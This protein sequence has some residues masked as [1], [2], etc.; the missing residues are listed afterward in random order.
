MAQQHIASS[1]ARLLYEF[2]AT[3][4]VDAQALLGPLPAPA[5]GLIPLAQWQVLL[6]RADSRLGEPAIG[7]RIAEGIGPQHFG[8]VGYAG[9]TCA[10]LADALQRLERYQ[11]LVYDVN[12][13]RVRA[14]GNLLLLEWGT[15]RGRPGQLVDETG[16]AA[17]V[18]L[19]R[20][21]CDQAL[22]PSEVHFVN[23]SP[24]DIGAYLDFFGCPVRFGQPAT[25]LSLPSAYLQLPLQQ[26]DPALLELL[27][28][29]A[30]GFLRQRGHSALL[31]S[32]Q[33]AL[34]RLLPEGRGNIADLA[35]QLNRSPRTLQ[36]HLQAEGSSFQQLLDDTRRQLAERYLSDAAL[37]LGE[38]AA[39]LGFSEQSAFSRA[40]RHWYGTAPLAWRR[41]LTRSPHAAPLDR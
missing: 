36:R 15:E 13:V 20:R 23:P 17:L 1:Y 24:A 26:A 8:V 40:F 7:L 4:G 22:L 2:L 12:P 10:T 19:A 27:D 37:P 35:G 11:G 41:H 28:E 18:Q 21:I 38:I 14:E 39:R 31:H 9:R 6:Q 5:S 16:V 33:Q 3:R 25:R 29:Q 30:E 34:A 32:C